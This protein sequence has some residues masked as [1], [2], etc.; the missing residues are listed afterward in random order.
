MGQAIFVGVDVSKDTL[1]V[2]LLPADEHLK[3][4]YD[5]EGIK[6]LIQ[7]LQSLPVQTIVMEAT[8]GYEKRL[9]AELCA[10]GLDKIHIV[11]PRK[12]RHFARSTGRLAKNDSLDAYI[13][14]YYGQVFQIKPQVFCFLSL[15]SDVLQ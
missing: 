12:I 13:L 2:C 10:A 7:K 8:G 9:A 6:Q 5:L 14:A 3:V 15:G 1:D 11:N 4:N